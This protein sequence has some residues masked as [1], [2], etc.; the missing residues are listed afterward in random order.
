MSYDEPIYVTIR[1][2]KRI[3]DNI[4]HTFIHDS[5]GDDYTL[6]KS[7]SDGDIIKVRCSEFGIVNWAL[8]YSDCVEVIEPEK[9]RDE[10]KKKI[11]KL[12]EKYGLKEK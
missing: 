1:I 6:L 5:F 11:K 2:T 8:Q 7:D 3:G 4:N 10:I 12:N 9:I